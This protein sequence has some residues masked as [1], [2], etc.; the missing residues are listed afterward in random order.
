VCIS[1][2]SAASIVC[3]L[4]DGRGGGGGLVALGI[5]RDYHPI[6]IPKLILCRTAPAKCW[7]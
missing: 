6:S 2:A 4:I 1:S 7:R 5:R 3:G